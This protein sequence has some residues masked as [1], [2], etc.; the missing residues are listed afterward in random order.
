MRQCAVLAAALTAAVSGGSIVL[1]APAGHAADDEAQIEA[2]VGAFGR[3]CKTAIAEKFKAK[4]MADVEVTFAAS[5]RTSIDAGEMRLAD[6]KES[7]LSCN[8]RVRHVPG[9]DP[10]GYCNADGKGNAEEIKNLPD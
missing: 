5:L 4:S 10:V 9:K 3:N 6:I 7:G 1:I 2:R 8:S